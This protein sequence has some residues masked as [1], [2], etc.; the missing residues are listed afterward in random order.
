MKYNCF[1]SCR[2][3]QIELA[4]QPGLL[5]VPANPPV[6]LGKKISILK[7]EMTLLMTIT[8]AVVSGPSRHL[9]R[10][11]SEAILG[12]LR[13]CRLLWRPSEVN[14]E[15]RIN[16][17]EC[18]QQEDRTVSSSDRDCEAK[19]DGVLHLCNGRKQDLSTRSKKLSG[20]SYSMCKTGTYA[21]STPIYQRISE[22]NSNEDSSKDSKIVINKKDTEDSCSEDLST[23]ETHR[24]LSTNVEESLKG[25]CCEKEQRE[26]KKAV[27]ERIGSKE[28]ETKR[29]QL[30]RQNIEGRNTAIRK[31]I[32]SL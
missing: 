16:T 31:G 23:S 12:A 24:S 29:I 25:N 18:K 15:A 22:E 28:R 4:G 2:V 20:N 8:F 1:L 11:Y 32:I 9:A 3:E 30:I 6:S 13:C 10:Q 7:I 19:E 26:E 5:L 27:N 17:D 21:P 14:Q